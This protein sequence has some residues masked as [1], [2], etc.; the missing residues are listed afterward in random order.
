MDQR[1]HATGSHWRK[2]TKTIPCAHLTPKHLCSLDTKVTKPGACGDRIVTFVV[3]VKDSYG[4]TSTC[5]GTSA[6]DGV[7]ACPTAKVEP[8]T[9]SINDLLEELEKASASVSQGKNTIS[10][11][12]M[13]TKTMAV[14]TAKGEKCLVSTA[15]SLCVVFCMNKML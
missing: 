3:Q 14:K 5:G 6:P 9:G 15:P 10:S 12:D 7:H 11:S 4:A 8:F 13:L 2:H 1:S